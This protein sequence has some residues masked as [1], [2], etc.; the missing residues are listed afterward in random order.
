MAFATRFHPG[1]LVIDGDAEQLRR[2]FINLIENALA[3]LEGPGRIE[4]ATSPGDDGR[5]ARILVSDTGRGM[6]AEDR[7]RLFLP[8]VST[9]KEGG[10]LGLAIVSD[11]VA[12]HGGTVRA[13][14]NLPHGTVFVLEFPLHRESPPPAEI[15]EARHAG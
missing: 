13:E 11:I 4:I 15:M 6:P 10:G 5:T 1:P 12:G 14:D 7:D 8:Y 9:K 2:V 3:A